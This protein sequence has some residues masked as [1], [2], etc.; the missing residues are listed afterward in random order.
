MNVV[1]ALVSQVL[2]HQ[3]AKPT[4]LQSAHH[5]MH[6]VGLPAH[7][8]EPSLEKAALF[9]RLNRQ[10]EPETV[11]TND[12]QCGL[13]KKPVVLATAT[14][15]TWLAQAMR[16]SLIPRACVNTR[17]MP[18]ALANGTTPTFQPSHDFQQASSRN[19]GTGQIKGI[20][21]CSD[22][23]RTRNW[24]N[25][26]DR[27]EKDLAVGKGRSGSAVE[28]KNPGYQKSCVNDREEICLRYEIVQGIAYEGQTS[29]DYTHVKKVN[30]ATS[31]RHSDDTEKALSNIQCQTICRLGHRCKPLRV[32]AGQS[33]FV[34][35]ET[36]HLLF[37]CNQAARAGGYRARIPAHANFRRRRKV[38][39]PGPG[40]QVRGQSVR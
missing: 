19:P 1:L 21:A 7:G 32:T 13:C 40:A 23:T 38:A 10:I 2:L 8:I 15:L 30:V 24:I 22:R 20:E 17:L 39:R 16:L 25:E 26:K 37:L 5:D 31:M 35:G 28:L 34:R 6:S 4:P 9:A 11:W 14:R 36:P 29:L 18:R 12:S 33:E 3:L 27:I